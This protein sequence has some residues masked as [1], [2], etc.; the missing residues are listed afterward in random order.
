[1]PRGQDKLDSLEPHPYLR[2]GQL[3]RACPALVSH[4]PCG[5]HITTQVDL[6]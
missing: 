4:R 6:P 1:M 2:F 3:Q 5:K